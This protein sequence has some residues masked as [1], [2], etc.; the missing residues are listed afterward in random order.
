[1]YE[2]AKGFVSQRD[3]DLLSDTVDSKAVTKTYT[4]TLPITG[5]TDNTGYFTKA[6]TVA[7]ILATDEPILD[8]VTTTSGFEAEQEA[9][10][11]VFKA[12]T[13]ANTI[14]FYASEVPATAVNF[15]AKVVR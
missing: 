2:I 10:G 4:G 13:S 9:W 15:T 3:F 14:T 1:M 6:V 8:L 7:G 5:W 12:V 11:K